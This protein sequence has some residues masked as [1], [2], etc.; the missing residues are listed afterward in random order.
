MADEKER[1]EREIKGEEEEKK[2]RDVFYEFYEI[3]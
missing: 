3:L 1:E 2:G